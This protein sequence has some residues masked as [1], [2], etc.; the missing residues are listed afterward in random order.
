MRLAV[1]GHVEWVQFARVER[2]PASGEIV[3]A[4]EVWEEPAGGGAVV[5][6]QLARLGAEVE[7]HT[8]LGDDALGH[9]AADRFDELGI[10]VQA[11][12]REEPT[13]RAFTHVDA[14]G[15]RTITVLGRK[16]LPR[17]PL[18]LDL[19]GCFF[20]AGDAAALRSAREAG[21]LA[22][23]AREQA[24]LR[25]AAV[26]L[27]LLVGSENDPGERAGEGI[28][29]AL[30]VRTDGARGGTANGRRYEP[31]P[32]PGPVSDAYGCGDSFAAA[33]F[34]A[35]VRGDPLEEALAL[36]ARA[37]AAVLTGRGPYEA[38]ISG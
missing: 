3:H 34:L 32:L 18:P 13:R 31:A 30:V 11:Q 24:T 28:E 17:G 10:D 7:F 33:L 36:A 25:K 37:G 8:A 21:F 15:E 19:D 12:W 14:A 22:A 38:Q 4:T 1:V 27:D 35:L 9:L 2:M 20:V 29:A 23:T 16:L 26:P 6:A 5:A